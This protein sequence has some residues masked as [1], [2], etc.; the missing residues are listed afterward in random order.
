M[1]PLDF[2]NIQLG[3]TTYRV[4]AGET[5]QI[6]TATG[7]VVIATAVTP[8]RNTSVAFQKIAGTG[9]IAID[10]NQGQLT[11]RK[12][13]IRYQKNRRRQVSV[14]PI[15]TYFIKGLVKLA[16]GTLNKGGDSTIVDLNAASEIIGFVN[17]GS[18]E[19]EFTAL[20]KRNQDLIIRENGQDTVFVGWFNKDYSG[21]QWQGVN[22]CGAIGS[23]LYSSSLSWDEY[24]TGDTWG[25]TNVQS[26][27]NGD[28]SPIPIPFSN[29]S[30]AGS[31]SSNVT[32]WFE[33]PP[34]NWST[35]NVTSLEQSYSYDNPIIVTNYGQIVDGREVLNK[36]TQ[37]LF[38]SNS[39]RSIILTSP[40]DWNDRITG[41]SNYIYYHNVTGSRSGSE[42]YRKN[43]QIFLD[44]TALA[45]NHVSEDVVYGG[46]LEI[47]RD[48]RVSTVVSTLD[49][50]SYLSAGYTPSIGLISQVYGYAP[51]AVFSRSGTTTQDNTVSIDVTTLLWSAQDYYIYGREQ[52]T[53]SF[54]RVFTKT[55]DEITNISA[56][57]GLYHHQLS[58]S[59]HRTLWIKEYY[60]TYGSSWYIQSSTEIVDSSHA[61]TN[62]AVSPGGDFDSI[63]L[64]NTKNNSTTDINTNSVLFVIDSND[65]AVN[66][67]VTAE[68]Y[69]A[70][71]GKSD[72]DGM[73]YDVPLKYT[74][75]SALV[76][77]SMVTSLSVETWK[78]DT[79]FHEIWDT[80]SS[81]EYQIIWVDSTGATFIGDVNVT[82]SDIQEADQF[83][84]SWDVNTPDGE[85]PSYLIGKTR[86]PVEVTFTILNKTEIRA[87]MLDL[88]FFGVIISKDNYA[89]YILYSQ[90]GLFN[91]YAVS[92]K[93]NS[94]LRDGIPTIATLNTPSLAEV[95]EDRMM[96]AE[97]LQMLPDGRWVR[98]DEESAS[99]AAIGTG[100][101]DP[102]SGW[103]SYYRV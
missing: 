34:Y 100:T 50:P 95:G 10:P 54:S 82:V 67:S 3:V 69:F 81:R 8:I 23:S 96:Y 27:F 31:S 68:V 62:F 58:S 98:R 37:L 85:Y 75:N 9:W 36:N 39:A 25:Y 76:N 4:A 99:V 65:F 86:Y 79:S 83:S 29:I 89:N 35:N 43:W 28:I 26:V 5:L 64:V 93:V 71:L 77:G 19:T 51:T 7:D 33:G 103:W 57:G 92:K 21:M 55:Y 6:T 46:D 73:F 87:S 30:K 53:S 61:G 97:I 15:L 1:K 63:K 52:A 16:D 40:L 38:T 2:E 84:F 94:F 88:A 44:R 17:T 45:Q 91:S 66:V 70:A 60:D 102:D 11:S 59:P 80:I 72:Y 41:A 42:S 49:K 47:K 90:M 48:W 101:P 18:N 20:W 74:A 13:E 14:T 32:G 22:V 78:D 12:Q 56:G 24:D